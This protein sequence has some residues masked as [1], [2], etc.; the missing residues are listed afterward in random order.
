M[1]MAP[2]TAVDLFTR[3]GVSL[4]CRFMDPLYDPVKKVAN[5]LGID[6]NA[7][8]GQPIISHIAGKL[9]NIIAP[10]TEEE[11]VIIRG[12]TAC[13]LF[14]HIRSSLTLGGDLSVKVGTEIGR[15]I[16][17]P[18]SRPHLHFGVNRMGFIIIDR[19]SGWGWGR[20]PF[21]ATKLQVFARGWDDPE[22]HLRSFA[23]GR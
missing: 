19:P 23:S 22:N 6:M 10:W 21:S 13:Y 5:H 20:C 14:G 3:P 1:A 7:D 2:K 11:C 12:E 17:Y 18:A 8:L 9:I 15:I 16:P 4:E